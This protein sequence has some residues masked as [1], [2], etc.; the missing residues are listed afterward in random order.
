MNEL[1]PP[2]QEEQHLLAHPTFPVM[3]QLKA[4]TK[5]HTVFSAK[6]TLDYDKLDISEFVYSFLEF[7]QQQPQLYYK[8]LLQFLQLRMEKAMSYSWL[9]VRNFNLSINQAFVQGRLTWAQMDVVQ[10]RSNRLSSVMLIFVPV[11]I[12]WDQ[13][14]QVHAN[15]A[16]HPEESR[17]IRIV[18]TGI[19]QSNALVILLTWSTRTPITAKCVILISILCSIV[20]NR[21]IPFLPTG[22]HSQSHND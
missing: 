19:I 4:S 13:S 2:S 17:K 5:G 15:H 10:A 8:N 16:T 7:V 22:L 14:L 1:T 3:Q 12:M 6:G 21:D 20:V 9:S 18:L 11:R